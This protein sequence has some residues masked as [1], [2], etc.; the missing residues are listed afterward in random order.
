MKSV[1]SPLFAILFS[2]KACQNLDR[3]PRFQRLSNSQMWAHH[4]CLCSSG[5]ALASDFKGKQE[6]TISDSLTQVEEQSS[7][8][9]LIMELTRGKFLLPKDTL[10]L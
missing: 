3:M 1:F 5:R 9:G 6:E 4:L 2:K 8:F 7:G 10:Y